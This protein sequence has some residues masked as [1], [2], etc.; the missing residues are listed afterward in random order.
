MVGVG[1]GRS[2]KVARAELLLSASRLV[3]LP[4]L[5]FGGLVRVI[6]IVILGRL[7]RGFGGRLGLVVLVC[8][9]I[10]ILLVA[11]SFQR[12]CGSLSACQHVLEMY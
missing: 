10:G 2:D 3:F 5:G 12:I 9:L 7:H 11:E 8:L 4:V 1:S 6:V